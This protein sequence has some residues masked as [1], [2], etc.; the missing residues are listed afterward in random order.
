MNLAPLYGLRVR[1]PRLELRLGTEAE[2]AAL[3]RLAE[4][5]VHLPD[6]MPFA[7]AW[8]DAIGTQG[9]MD[10]F[11][12]YHWAKREGW[13]PDAW[14]LPLLTWA[15][16]R[17]AGTQELMGEGFAAQ[18]EV[19]TGSW[20]GLG[21]QRRGIGTEMRAA[22]LELAFAGLGA[23]TARSSWLQGNDASR[24]VSEKL[25]YRIVGEKVSEP[26]AGELVPTTIVQIDRADW[27]CPVPVE[28]EGLEP[29][30]PLFGLSRDAGAPG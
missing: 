28:I 5:G 22:V 3:G 9:F 7:I 18:R 4:E 26:R 13:S 25:G 21:F 2:L 8:T 20:L 12:A 6:E 29:C 19:H 11:L 30:L 16:G 10:G 1:T 14:A 17:L 24:R 23:R 15:D 27:H